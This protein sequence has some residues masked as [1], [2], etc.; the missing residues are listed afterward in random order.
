MITE[1]FTFE[2][3]E[4]I[5]VLSETTDKGWQIELNLVSW[6]GGEPRYDIRSWNAD[7]TRSSKVSTFSKEGLQKFINELSKVTI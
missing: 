2:I 7:H 6:N 4:H 1:D 3:K 5:A